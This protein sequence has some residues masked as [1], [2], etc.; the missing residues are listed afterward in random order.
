MTF[1][2]D[3]DLAILSGAEVRGTLTTHRLS[4]NT[5]ALI[6]SD[7]NAQCAPSAKRP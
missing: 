5:M 2:V 6:T 1:K 7:C 3:T 4:S